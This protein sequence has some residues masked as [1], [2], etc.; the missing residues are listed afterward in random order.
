MA[1]RS[2]FRRIFGGSEAPPAEPP[3]ANVAQPAEA[4]A[5]APARASWLQRL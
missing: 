5:P 3:N 2:V 1:E 4:P